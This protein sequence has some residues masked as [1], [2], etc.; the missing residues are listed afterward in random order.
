[1]FCF[2]AGQ[3]ILFLA[4]Q[5]LCAVRTASHPGLTIGNE[6]QSEWSIPQCYT[7]QW[8]SDITLR[9]VARKSTLTA[10]PL[11]QFLTEDEWDDILWVPPQF[12]ARIF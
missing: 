5:P 9:H 11:M 10:D 6:R 7:Q 8:S 2:A 12:A 1:M 4:S 3:V